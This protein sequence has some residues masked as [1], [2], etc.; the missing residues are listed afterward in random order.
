MAE[1]AKTTPV[2]VQEQQARDF[3]VEEIVAKAAAA[4][5]LNTPSLVASIVN[6][7]SHPSARP[8]KKRR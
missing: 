8:P 2:P 3:A 4:D 1:S 5:A 6:E 7:L